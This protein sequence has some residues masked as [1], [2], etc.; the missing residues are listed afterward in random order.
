MSMDEVLFTKACILCIMEE[1]EVHEPIFIDM[2]YEEGNDN[3]LKFCKLLKTGPAAKPPPLRLLSLMAI[4]SSL[5]P[6]VGE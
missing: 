4:T 3:H 5:T 6:E 1:D 2:S